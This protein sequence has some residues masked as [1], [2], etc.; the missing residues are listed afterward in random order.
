MP[1]LSLSPLAAAAQ[2]TRHHLDFHEG[3]IEPLATPI[4]LTFGFRASA[5]TYTDP[6]NHVEL[7][8]SR[9][10]AAQIDAATLALQLWGD[11]ANVSLT[12]VGTGNVGNSAYTDQATILIGNFNNSGVGAAGVGYI[13]SWNTPSPGN[14][15]SEHSDGDFWLNLAYFPAPTT[16][17]PGSYY[18][19]LFLHELGHTLGLAHPGDYGGF[20]TYENNAVYIEDTQQYT[21]MSY[22]PA[23]KTGA[24]HGGIYGSTPLLEDIAALQRYYGANQTT[25]TGDTVYGFN[26]NADRTVFHLTS[27]AQ[28]IV[29]AIWDAGGNDTLDF[30][31]YATNQVIDLREGEFS[32]VGALTKNVAIAVGATIENGI[33]GSGNDFLIGNGAVNRLVGGPGNDTIDGGGATDTAIFSGLR[34]AYTISQSGG[35]FQVSGPDGTDQLLN[36][37][38]AAFS[39]Q[40]VVLVSTT[41]WLASTTIGVHPPGYQISGIGDFNKDGTSDVLWYNQS[42][43]DTDIWSLNNG[44]WAGSSTIGLHPA[45]YQI[46]GIGDFNKDG[47][48]DVLWYNPTTRD[49]DIW[50]VSNGHWA[51]S[52]TIGVHPAGY[53]IVGIGDFNKDGT[54]DVLWYNPTT[55]D[56]DIWSLNNGQW[57]G[58]T[59]IGV[60]PAGYQVAG[61]GD[62]NN[63]GTSDVLWFNPTT[64][65]TDIWAVSNGH[66]AGSTTIGVHPAG[67]QIAGVGDFNQD[68]TS[69]VVWY[70]PSNNDIDVWLVKNGQWAASA[71]V[72]AHPP[73]STLAGVGDFDHNGVADIM[74]RDANTGNVETWLIAFS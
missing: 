40:T 72:G 64:R 13:P 51:G 35:G 49:T 67:Y 14:K 20:A 5:P 73:G 12:R 26:S 52:T 18:F 48:S 11:V 58:S 1:T 56:T 15:V 16:P 37:E 43:R 22:F 69:D 42:T 21:V 68:G 44:K 70:N 74:W 29:F 33:G 65:E 7:S 4:A 9:F 54:S 61:V 59:T 6:T 31:G 23:S 47:T 3:W 2:I 32:S 50:A 17:Q 24:D 62:F 10:D 36:I 25:R 39:D 46:S 30:S 41:H 45:G 57:A 34:S 63:D 28:S 53:D 71:S 66:W 19:Q 55:R 27:A 38:N 8:F 60:H